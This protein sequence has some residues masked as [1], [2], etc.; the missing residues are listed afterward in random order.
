M[1]VVGPGQPDS[2]A[3][4]PGTGAAPRVDPWWD[5]ASRP[6]RAAA[7]VAILALICGTLTHLVQLV[8]GHS[9]PYPWA[10]HWLASYDVWLTLVDP[11]AAVLLLRGQRAG[12]VLGGAVLASDAL[13][14]AYG[15]YVLRP[16]AGH[17]LDRLAQAAVTVTALVLASAAP[18]LWRAGR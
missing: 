12:L 3:D 16:G 17:D 14:G 18:R 10:P 11:V 2:T 13:A 15:V 7:L 9:H 6:A 4:G 5:G 8:L 1:T